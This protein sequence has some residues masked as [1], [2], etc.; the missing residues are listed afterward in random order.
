MGEYAN[1]KSKKFYQLLKWLSNHKRFEIVQGGRHVAKDHAIETNCSYPL[2]L[3]HKEV[4]K[5]IVKDFRDWL[6]KNSICTAEEFD[7]IIK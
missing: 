6:V 1:I 3:S 5:N 7:D 4:N 2:P